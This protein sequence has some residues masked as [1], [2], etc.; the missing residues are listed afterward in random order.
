MS[1][2]AAKTGGLAFF[3]SL[4]ALAYL[5]PI[6]FGTLFV[7]SLYAAKPQLIAVL[8]A[9][10]LGAALSRLCIRGTLFTLLHEVKHSV[11]SGLVGNKAKGDIVVNADGS[12]EFRYAY[13]KYTAH[14]NAFI[15]LAPYV[16]PLCAGILALIATPF[17]W[18]HSGAIGIVAAF[19]LGIDLESNARDVSPMQS[20]L[21]DIRGGFPVAAVYA[22]L[23]NTALA[24]FILM[25]CLFGLYGGRVAAIALWT[26]TS[27]V[28]FWAREY[29]SCCV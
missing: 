2:E 27:K 25:L 13:T 7:A 24:S 3:L 1:K 21:S 20:D 10:L 19:G 28:V 26:V 23:T 18:H 16:L 29:V 22:A 17:A 9:A 5:A 12:G 4:A 11:L 6:L 15:A 14:Y 8:S